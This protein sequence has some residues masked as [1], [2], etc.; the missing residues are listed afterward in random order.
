MFE[1]RISRLVLAVSM[2]IFAGLTA[3]CESDVD[4]QMRLERE[5]LEKQGDLEELEGQL[6]TVNPDP[7]DPAV[8]GTQNIGRSRQN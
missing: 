4:R 2:V 7:Y 1:A 6:N 5:A 3:A 8:R